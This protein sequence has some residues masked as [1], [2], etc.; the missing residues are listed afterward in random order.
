MTAIDSR[1]LDERYA[2]PLDAVSR[3][4]SDGF[5]RLAGLLSPAT[6]A[7]YGDAIDAE[8]ARRNTLV[9]P[10]HERTT[11]ERA[12]LQVMTLWTGSD[13]VRRFVFS[14]R[15]A[16]IAAEL[17]GVAGVRLYHDQALYKEAGG[18]PTPWHADQYYWPLTTTK[19]CTIWIPLQP[20]PLAMGP[21]AF[22]AGSH[23]V[24][25]GRDL[26]ISDDSEA[27][28]SQA[29]LATKLPMDEA[30]FELGEISVHTGWTFHRAGANATDQPRRVMTIIYIDAAMRVAE[31]SNHNQRVDLATWF[32][33]LAAGDLAASPLNPGIPLAT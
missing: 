31:P 28:I 8:V 22:S 5:V 6:L 26:P 30:P 18:G 32:P 29:L 19:S 2:L 10:M 4:A 14:S 23:H 7:H 13:R 3:F 27:R 25:L 24:N 20:T 17:M 9:K 21:V 11:Y 16:R 15:L 1:D 12:F 33:G